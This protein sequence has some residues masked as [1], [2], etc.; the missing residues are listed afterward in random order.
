MCWHCGCFYSYTP[1]D[2]WLVPAM[3]KSHQERGINTLNLQNQCTYVHCLR[4]IFFTRSG[5]VNKTSLILHCWYL[6]SVFNSCE[7]HHAGTGRTKMAMISLSFSRLNMIWDECRMKW[8]FHT[9][10]LA[11]CYIDLSMQHPFHIISFQ[12]YYIILLTF[13][14]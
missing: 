14:Y 1:P 4:S 7:T 10:L 8:Q 5:L 11:L 6:K 12:E 13:P 2:P 9:Q 3:V